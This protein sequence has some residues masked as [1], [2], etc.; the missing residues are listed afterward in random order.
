MEVT[1][2]VMM[3]IRLEGLIKSIQLKDMAKFCDKYPSF[4]RRYVIV[5]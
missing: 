3:M 4:Y 5:T 1:N 2:S